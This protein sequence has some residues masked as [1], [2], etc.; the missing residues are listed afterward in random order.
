MRFAIARHILR[1]RP[2]EI[3][4]V[5]HIRFRCSSGLW[6]RLYRTLANLEIASGVWISNPESKIFSATLRALC[7]GLVLTYILTTEYCLLTTCF[8]LG[9][10]DVCTNRYIPLEQLFGQRCVGLDI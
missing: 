8:K 5:F 10:N 6:P 9:F 2:S 1:Y 3:L 4:N 7:G